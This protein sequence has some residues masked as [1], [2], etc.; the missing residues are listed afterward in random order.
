MESRQPG[1]LAKIAHAWIDQDG[2]VAFQE[3]QSSALPPKLLLDTTN[4]VAYELVADDPQLAFDFVFEV[5]SHELGY[6]YR[7]LA[8]EVTNEWAQ[9]D[10]ASAFDATLTMDGEFLQ[11]ELQKTV[12]RQWARKDARALLSN[13]NNFPANLHSVVRQIA[14][15]ESADKTVETVAELLGN[16]RERKRREDVAWKVAYH[17]AQQDIVAT[18]QWIETDESISHIQQKLKEVSFRQLA[19]SS[20]HLALQIALSQPLEADAV[21]LEATVV[22]ATARWGSL[23]VAISMLPQVRSDSTRTDAFD[24]V[25]EHSLLEQD[26]ERALDLFLQLCEYETISTNGPL[27]TV[28]KELSERLFD[29]IDTITSEVT[30]GRVA[31]ELYREHIDGDVFSDHQLSQLREMSSPDPSDTR[32]E[33]MERVM[34]RMLLERE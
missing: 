4:Y 9:P 21:G 24:A 25:I 8:I 11:R 34:E 7:N 16:I 30:K 29:S 23:D 12:L 14:V 17:W 6:E 33:A 28:I 1:V 15:I 2:F 19:Q 26:P 10:P 3:M 13:L 5:Y 32:R 31:R 22:D 18:L 27:D 20:P